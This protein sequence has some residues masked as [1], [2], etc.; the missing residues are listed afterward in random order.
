M[1]YGRRRVGK[2]ELIKQALTEVSGTKIYYECKQVAEKNNVDG[3]AEVTSAAL[4]FPKLAFEDMESVL[5][6][7]FES[8]KKGKL[9]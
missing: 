8:S 1:V 3:L 2:N 5:R 7:L 4:R 9:F 6:F